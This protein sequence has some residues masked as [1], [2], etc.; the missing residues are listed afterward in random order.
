MSARSTFLGLLLL[1]SSRVCIKSPSIP[2]QRDNLTTPASTLPDNAKDSLA[3]VLPRLSVSSRLHDTRR[4]GQNGRMGVGR[5]LSLRDGARGRNNAESGRGQYTDAVRCVPRRAD[6]PLPLVVSSRLR[7]SCF[8]D[9]DARV[10]RLIAS[11]QIA[12]ELLLGKVHK[13]CDQPAV[14]SLSNSI[15]S[16][17]QATYADLHLWWLCYTDGETLAFSPSMSSP[18]SSGY[19]GM[20]LSVYRAAAADIAMAL[21]GVRGSRYVGRSDSALLRQ[22]TLG[23]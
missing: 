12:R 2:R 4:D 21:F 13:G 19:T 7:Y 23:L 6:A 5:E 17:A 16:K 18:P 14:I 22:S 11:E 8:R 15:P 20:G 3:A 9:A 10:S 1:L